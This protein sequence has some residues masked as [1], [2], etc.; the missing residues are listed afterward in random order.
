[1][2]I[3][4]I[5]WLSLGRVAGLPGRVRRGTPRRSGSASTPLLDSNND[6]HQDSGRNQNQKDNDQALAGVVWAGTL[7][8][9]GHA[10][11]V[12]QIT[13]GGKVVR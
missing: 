9:H 1:M 6:S 10:V 8:R 13:R 11:D 2:T 4:T 5:P 3:R 7:L 12:L